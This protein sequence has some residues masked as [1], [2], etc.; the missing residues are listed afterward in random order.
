M[1]RKRSRIG[2]IVCI[3]GGALILA[4]VAFAAVVSLWQIS[5][6]SGGNGDPI[7]ATFNWEMNMVNPHSHGVTA[8]MVPQD[9][10]LMR[11][12]RWI[13]RDETVDTLTRPSRS[14]WVHPYWRASARRVDSSSSSNMSHG[15]NY[16]MEW[17]AWN[18]HATGGV[19]A[20]SSKGRGSDYYCN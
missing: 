3:L 14:I 10:R 17:D 16:Y 18:V 2:L 19:T 12:R 15:N 20:T 11:V 7:N 5:R 1:E 8:T 6:P 9:A 4:P 13:I